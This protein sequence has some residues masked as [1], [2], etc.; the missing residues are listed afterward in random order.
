MSPPARILIVIGITA[1]GFT[2]GW[3]TCTA[4]ND[5]AE[6][7]Q[8]RADARLQSQFAINARTIGQRLTAEIQGRANDA[9]RHRAAL[10]HWE[11]KGTVDVKCPNAPGFSPIP[12]SAVR[13]GAGFIADWNRGLCLSVP[14][15]DACYRQ[16]ADAET[17][18]G[19]SVTPAELQ[20]NLAD[21]AE[22]CGNDRA[23]LRGWQDLARKNGWVSDGD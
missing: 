21:N 20:R 9:R 18:G 4:F 5:A 7:E 15:G 14:D 10:R 22:A 1:I 8:L 11:T 2:V 19:D 16:H 23:T 13:F 12:Q 17:R 6:A 3:R